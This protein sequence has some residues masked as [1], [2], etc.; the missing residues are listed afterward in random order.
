MINI[1][2]VEIFS[3]VFELPWLIILIISVIGFLFTI[4]WYGFLFKNTLN[5]LSP[6]QNKDK[7]VMIT[8]FLEMLILSYFVTLIIL[9]LPSS[10][11]YLIIDA[12]LGVI[13]FGLLVGQMSTNPNRKNGW[14]LWFLH[15]CYYLITVF[16]MFVALIFLL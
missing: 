2:I 14:K 4:F 6:H 5:K 7:A 9:F 3:I 15:T 11:M 1:D 8:S 10:E 12:L 13:I 16:G